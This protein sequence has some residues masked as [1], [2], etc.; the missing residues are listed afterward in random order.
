MAALLAAEAHDHSTTEPAPPPGSSTG[1]DDVQHV[2][3]ET[4]TLMHPG[5]ITHA[6]V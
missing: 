6:K 3:V 4:M 5:L 1:P 2:S